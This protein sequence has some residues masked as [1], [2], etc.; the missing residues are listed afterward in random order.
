[1]GMCNFPDIFQEKINEMFHIIEF[2]IAYIDDLSVTTKGYW[3]NSLDK[4]ELA[5]KKLSTNG[6]K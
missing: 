6:L 3:Y 5:L 1:M 2:I 4:L